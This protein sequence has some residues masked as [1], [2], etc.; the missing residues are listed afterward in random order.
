[1]RS[2]FDLRTHPIYLG[3]KKRR[4]LNSGYFRFI[5]CNSS[6]EQKQ[7]IIVSKMWSRVKNI[8]KRKESNYWS[9]DMFSIPCPEEVYIFTELSSGLG[10]RLP[11][12]NTDQYAIIEREEISLN[13]SY[14]QDDGADEKTG[15]AIQASLILEELRKKSP[16][17][18]KQFEA[19][20]GSKGL[21]AETAL[22][23]WEDIFKPWTVLNCY[24][25]ISEYNYFFNIQKSRQSTDVNS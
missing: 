19:A 7:L 20:I 12:Y 17:G 16:P 4:L 21:D 8:F 6:T 1:M 9:R 13:L 25:S 5:R 23:L 10:R 15:T 24:L 22:Q 3:N 11:C 2:L 18:F 14:Q